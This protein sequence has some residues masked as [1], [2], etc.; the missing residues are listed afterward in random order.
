MN[1]LLFAICAPGLEEAA[2]REIESR[3]SPK[4]LH[5]EQGGVQF[6]A[7]ALSAN[8]LLSLPT[9]ILQRIGSFPAKNFD[10]LV[11]G[12]KSLKFP[13]GVH[14]ESVAT[15]KSRLY[16]T[17]AI[18][19]HLNAALPQG[20]VGLYVRLDRDQC[21]ISIDTTGEPLHK[22]GWRL[23]T[24]PAP[25]RETLAA[26][27]L[28]LAGWQPGVPLVDPMCGSGTF[29][30]EAAVLA[31]GRA[32]GFMRTFACEAWLPKAAMPTF[33]A[34]ETPMLGGDRNRSALRAAQKNAERAG[35]QLSFFH[36]D[37]AQF[38]LDS[39]ELKSTSQGGLIVCNPPY[40]RRAPDAQV[41]IDRLADLLAR[42]PHWRAAILCPYT[43]TNAEQARTRFKRPIENIYRLQNGGLPIDLLCFCAI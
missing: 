39:A 4:S 7:N 14:V 16:H 12:A 31:A 1:S 25:L 13:K 19:E 34:V 24:G 22:R 27:I 11:A 43:G 33:K 26:A 41:A 5:I 2:A 32:P 40:D 28:S 10:A 30:I 8:R 15:H 3:I 6:E 17:K 21:T 37:A 29:L 38:P 9:R 35:V 23:E 36:G 20:E 18:E 42:Y